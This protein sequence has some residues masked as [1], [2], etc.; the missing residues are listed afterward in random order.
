[1]SIFKNALSLHKCV[2]TETVYH[3]STFFR[4]SFFAVFRKLP[5]ILRLSFPVLAVYL[6]TRVFRLLATV[7]FRFC[8][9]FC[10]IVSLIVLLIDP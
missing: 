6:R 7:I 5:Y 1:M 8:L 9:Y 3:V 2:W 4:D 10:F